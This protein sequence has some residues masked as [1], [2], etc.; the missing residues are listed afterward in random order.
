MPP[1][2]LH[3]ACESG[4]RARDLQFG[5]AAQPRRLGHDV[6]FYMQLNLHL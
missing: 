6:Y 4:K 2:P 5:G 3:F 1:S